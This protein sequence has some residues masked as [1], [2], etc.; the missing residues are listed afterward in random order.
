MGAPTIYRWDDVNAP[1]LAG[2]E[3]SLVNLLTKVLVDGYGSKAGLGWTREFVNAG[4]TIAVFRNDP[5]TGTGFFLRVDDSTAR[6][7]NAPRFADLVGYEVMADLNTGNGRFPLTGAQSVGKSNTANTTARAWVVVG[8]Q[9]G[10][11]LFAWY[12]DNLPITSSLAALAFWF[13]DFVS[14]VPGDAYA[15]C[16]IAVNEGSYGY[17]GVFSPYYWLARAAGGA[18]G[19]I[20]GALHAGAGPGSSSVAGNLGATYPW[21]GQLLVARPW[22]SDS[23]SNSFRGWLPGLYYPC[24]AYPLNNFT[25]TAHGDKSLLAVHTN[26]GGHGQLLIDTSANW[27]P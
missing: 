24:H 25:V 12:Y 9:R 26:N 20:A 7:G 10:F 8:D 19:A 6:G 11:Y 21:Y 22:L 2:T 15:C 16:N 1:V 23:A 18:V 27:R 14:E 5:A 17:L 13:G 4:Q 3:G